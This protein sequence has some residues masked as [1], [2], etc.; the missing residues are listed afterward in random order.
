MN[1]PDECRVYM[2]LS[3]NRGPQFLM[4]FHHVSLFKITMLSKL[5]Q[6]WRSPPGILRHTHMPV[7]LTIFSAMAASE[8]KVYHGIPHRI[9]G[10][11]NRENMRMNHWVPG[12]PISYV[13][14]KPI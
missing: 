3:E 7:H 13:S 6:I 14:Y 11:F 8:N 9:Y 1:R 2:A 10:M 5:H 12:Y 4:V